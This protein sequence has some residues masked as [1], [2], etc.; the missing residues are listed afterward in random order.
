MHERL[1]LRVNVLSPGLKGSC[2]TFSLGESCLEV[3]YLVE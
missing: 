1:V 3:G 2:W